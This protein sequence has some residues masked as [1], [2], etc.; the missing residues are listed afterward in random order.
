MHSMPDSAS[1]MDPCVLILCSYPTQDSARVPACI[2]SGLSCSDGQTH[3]FCILRR[4]LYSLLTSLQT[5]SKPSPVP[6]S[7]DAAS[8]AVVQESPLFATDSKSAIKMQDGLR[9]GRITWTGRTMPDAA[10]CQA[11]GQDDL[12]TSIL[13]SPPFS[14]AR[15]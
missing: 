3:V 15:K 2:I 5:Q 4:T 8:A 1:F 14:R 6:S 13:S 9:K 12:Q 7:D 10:F 11:F